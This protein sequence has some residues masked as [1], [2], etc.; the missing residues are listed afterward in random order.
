M[1]RK[2]IAHA[3]LGK[4]VGQEWLDLMGPGTVIDLFTKISAVKTA[5]P[6]KTEDGYQSNEKTW[7]YP[8]FKDL[9]KPFESCPADK[10]K[11]VILTTQ[12]YNN[13]EATGLPF[14]CMPSEYKAKTPIA[15]NQQ[16]VDC[17]DEAVGLNKTNPDPF[18]GIDWTNLA[19]QGVLLLH[20]CWTVEH[21]KN[22][23]HF[24]VWEPLTK[25][26]L[27]R[28]YDKDNTIVF[29]GIGDVANNLL[30]EILGDGNFI[31]APNAFYKPDEAR[32]QFRLAK[33]FMQLDTILK[34]RY[35]GGI[36]F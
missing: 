28:L 15:Y 29:M 24:N 21:A 14:Q 34:M 4:K 11:A 20:S 27:S 23:S 2:K 33:P 32:I 12:P 16:D 17:I 8:K 9:L 10:L 35:K 5:Y 26:L 36:E 19:S 30:R 6:N 7:I 13:G 3:V 18:F 22:L 25:K 1:S 31:P